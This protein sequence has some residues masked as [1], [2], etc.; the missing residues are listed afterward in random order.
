MLTVSSP[1]ASVLCQHHAQP[2]AECA[3]HGS[4]PCAACLVLTA[5][6]RAKVVVREAGKVKGHGAPEAS[7]VYHTAGGV[8][9]AADATVG[10]RSLITQ[11]GTC[12]T[13]A[14]L[15]STDAFGVAPVGGGKPATLDYGWRCH[16][17]VEFS[18]DDGAKAQG[19]R[20]DFTLDPYASREAC[21]HVN[22]STMGGGAIHFRPRTVRVDEKTKSRKL[23]TLKMSPLFFS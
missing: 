5:A 18:Q 21:T 7:F 9:L 16:P 10:S 4:V 22:F 3:N 20:F 2:C 12:D 1:Q 14:P 15:A 6:S 8:P 19:A 11:A 23:Q 13:T 17:G